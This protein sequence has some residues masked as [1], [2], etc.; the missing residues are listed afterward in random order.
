MSYN[1]YDAK[2]YLAERR[3]VRETSRNWL[4]NVSKHL[5][6]IPQIFWVLPLRKGGGE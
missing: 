6:V 2:E 4:H 5:P 3:K 1:R